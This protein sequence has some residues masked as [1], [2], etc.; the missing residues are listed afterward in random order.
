MKLLG[1]LFKRKH[2]GLQL[3]NIHTHVYD[4]I[5]VYNAIG[6]SILFN[7]KYFK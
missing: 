6:L 4:P 1:D 2:I 5:Y 7:H 3:T